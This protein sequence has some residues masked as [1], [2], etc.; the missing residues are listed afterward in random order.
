VGVFYDQSTPR[1]A[2]RSFIRALEQRRSDVIM[3]LIPSTE[4]E[5][6][7]L[8]RLEQAWSG[9]GRDEIER[10][11]NNLNN[12]LNNPIERVGKRATMPYGE[13]F[14]V[15]FVLEGKRWKIEKPE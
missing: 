4:K 2:L 1:A 7:T 15:E 11:V 10:I 3:R 8:K 13:Y 12:H 9:K 5:G 6:I 14:S